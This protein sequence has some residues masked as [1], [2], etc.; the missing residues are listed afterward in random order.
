MSLLF[1]QTN[2]TPGDAFA[3]GGG[4]GG[5]NFPQGILI[6]I[7]TSVGPTYDQYLSIYNNSNGDFTGFIAGPL[8]A[9]SGSVYGTIQGSAVLTA[10][11][12]NAQLSYVTAGGSSN[13]PF[14]T[15][16]GANQATLSNLN[17]INGK[18]P[19]VAES[20]DSP[21]P[22]EGVLTQFG[23]VSFSG[24]GTSDVVLNRPYAEYMRIFLTPT[25]NDSTPDGFFYYTNSN[26]AGFSVL[27][28]GSNTSV[29][30]SWLSIG[31]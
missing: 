23:V 17:L 28:T 14:A 13:I 2:I 6:G 8:T 16:A 19:V 7:S 31:W 24:N 9:T 11:S 20:T 21:S 12:S 15:F 25:A 5:S 22:T 18:F 30:V 26:L 4:G 27:S 3:S 1:N 29:D 10:D